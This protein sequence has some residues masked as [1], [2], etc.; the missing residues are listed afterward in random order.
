MD[1]NCG[2]WPKKTYVNE[3]QAFQNITLRRIA[4]A[5]PYV[6]NLTLHNDTRMKS[7][8][9]ESVIYLLQAFFCTSS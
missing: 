8:E 1:Y 6:S 2:D 4:S 9:K 3:I 7:I 5:P